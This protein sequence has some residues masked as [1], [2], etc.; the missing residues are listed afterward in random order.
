MGLSQKITLTVNGYNIILSRNLKLYQN[1]QIELIFEI[2]EY[3]IDVNGQTGKTMPINPLEA[4]L[5]FET[6]LGVTDVKAAN[7]VDNAV[8]FYLSSEHTQYVGVS[9][10]QIQLTDSDGCQITLPEF[11]FEI[12]KNIYTG[13]VVLSKFC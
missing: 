10:M 2:N 4:R 3:G 5:F 8:T 11:K 9:Y 13:E 7:I 1:D 6:P 12:R